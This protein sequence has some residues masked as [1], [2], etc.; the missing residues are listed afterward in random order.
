MMRVSLKKCDCG[1]V[2]CNKY[3]ICQNRLEP[4]HLTKEVGK[5]LVGLYNDAPM[6]ANK[7]RTKAALIADQARGDK[8]SEIVASQ[9]VT[10]LR[11]CAKE[12]D[13]VGK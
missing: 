1:Y 8:V 10:A 5:R 13:A 4:G 3:K 9:C 2:A 6:L 12:L 11:D 7:W